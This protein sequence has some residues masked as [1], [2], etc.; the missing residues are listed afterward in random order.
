M[1]IPQIVES[2]RPPRL[3]NGEQLQAEY[4]DL[5]HDPA[6]WEAT[7]LQQ[8]AQALAFAAFVRQLARARRHEPELVA[9]QQ[10]TAQLEQKCL[11][12]NQALFAEARR[13]IQSS[14]W[15]GKRL[16]Q[17]LERY[18]SYRNGHR[19]QPHLR[20]D[21][22]DVLVRGILE[23]DPV[24]PEAGVRTP[25]MVHLE[26]TPARAVLELVD[27]AGFTGKD[28]FYDLGSGL[29][30]VVFLVHLLTGVVATGV[31]IEPAYCRYAQRC[32]AALQ[33]EGVTFINE[34]ARLAD[35]SNG[36]CF[37][38]FTPFTGAVLEAVLDRLR[39]IASHRPITIAAYGSC[40]RAIARQPWLQPLDDHYEDEFKLALLRSGT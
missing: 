24:P 11:C 34:D 3:M 23:R 20:P 5:L 25:D 7:S 26:R 12:I 4:R 17:E 29:G 8:R 21:G 9:L 22:L 35:L 28:H 15:R 18:T 13:Q 6:L 19:G 36:T 1:A 27:R 38:L 32:A 33:V 2:R 30:Q 31:E 10:E 14:H 39:I 16:R 37:F 40:S